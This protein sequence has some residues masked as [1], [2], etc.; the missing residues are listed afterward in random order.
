M[1][2][3]KS[4]SAVLSTFN[5][6]KVSPVPLSLH[7]QPILGGLKAHF[8]GCLPGLSDG[9]SARAVSSGDAATRE[10]HA[11]WIPLH[12]TTLSEPSMEASTSWAA[13]GTGYCWE[14]PPGH[15]TWSIRDFGFD[16]RAITVVELS[17]DQ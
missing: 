7:F 4:L 17:C 9:K 10:S 16:G 6:L 2:D 12:R 14:R 8:F 11:S 3:A 13:A 15:A 1:K 5:Q